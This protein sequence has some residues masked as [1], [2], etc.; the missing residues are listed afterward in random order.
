MHRS[1]QVFGQGMLQE[2]ELLGQV[3]CCIGRAAGSSYSLYP[4]FGQP[5]ANPE[6]LG[7]TV[8]LS[9]HSRTT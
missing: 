6:T 8:D 5:T 7:V 4:D 1:I 2:E 9:S 3:G